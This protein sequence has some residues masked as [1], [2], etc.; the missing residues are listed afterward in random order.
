MPRFIGQ[1]HILKELQG[2]TSKLLLKEYNTNLLLRAPSGY[3]KTTLATIIANKVD[4]GYRNS[5]YYIPDNEGTVPFDSSKRFHVLDEVHL[6]KTPESLYDKMDSGKYTFIL[7][8]NESSRLKE[9]LVNRCIQFLFR[10]YSN[11]EAIEI[12]RQYINSLTESQYE[13]VRN[14]SNNNP[15]VIKKLCERLSV[16]TDNKQ[17]TDQELKSIFK[18]IF[19][20][21]GG[22]NEFHRR[23][24]DFL[25]KAGQSSITNIVYTIGLDRQ[26]ILQEIEPILLERGLIEI[27]SRGRKLVV[28]HI[29]QL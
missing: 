19:Q 28:N 5:A 21:E 7:A 24:L 27:T 29:D 10:K 23:Y 8:T 4:P 1:E 20:I 14:N 3:G 12:V 18:D 15:R 25:R 16:I 22:L 13:F 26:T 2:I 9:P 17:V 11:Q 6:L